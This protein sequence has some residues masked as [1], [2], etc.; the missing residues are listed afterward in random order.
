MRRVL[1]NGW[2]ILTQLH[3]V[4][5]DPIEHEL[6]PL[7]QI[8]VPEPQHADPLLFDE[9]LSTGIGLPCVGSVVDLTIELD[10]EPHLRCVEVDDVR[11]DAVLAAELAAGDAAAAEMFPEEDF[12]GCRRVAQCATQSLT[13]RHVV[14][15]QAHRGAN[16]CDRGVDDVWRR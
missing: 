2:R 12:G 4:T 3:D 7:E 16:G 6:D 14:E 15:D 11:S 8:A 1:A 13:A 5:R 9:C 10:G